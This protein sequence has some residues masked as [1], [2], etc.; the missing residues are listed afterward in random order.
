MKSD[1]QILRELAASVYVTDAQR[2]A[3]DRVVPRLQLEEDLARS[4]R[5]EDDTSPLAPV[6]P[7]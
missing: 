6:R 7:R 4:K 1:S 2:A 3:L 5:A